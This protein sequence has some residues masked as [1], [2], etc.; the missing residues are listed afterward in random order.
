MSDVRIQGH[1]HISFIRLQML[2]G[3]AVSDNGPGGCRG[4]STLPHFGENVTWLSAGAG[5]AL[6]S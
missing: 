2:R 6:E 1:H 4:G 5:G 3:R